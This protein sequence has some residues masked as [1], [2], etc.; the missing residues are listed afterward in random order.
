MRSMT[1]WA[2]IQLYPDHSFVQL[3]AQLCVGEAAD[4]EPSCIYIALYKHAI[5]FAKYCG[6]TNKKL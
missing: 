4:I 2:N 5:N 1:G 6:S 3:R